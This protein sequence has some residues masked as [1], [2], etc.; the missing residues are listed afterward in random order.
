MF[1][2]YRKTGRYFQLSTI[3]GH[4]FSAE[5]FR[6]WYGQPGEWIEPGRSVAD[7]NNYGSPPCLWAYHCETED[8]TKFLAGG[9]AR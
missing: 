6:D 1:G 9:I 2:G 7:P 3:T 5:D 8:G 4:F